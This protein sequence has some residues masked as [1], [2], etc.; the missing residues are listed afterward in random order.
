M[1]DDFV[2]LILT[3]R[4]TKRD[5][6]LFSNNVSIT[7][8][9]PNSFLRVHNLFLIQHTPPPSSITSGSYFFQVELYNVLPSV[10]SGNGNTSKLLL[11][12]AIHVDIAALVIQWTP[13]D[14]EWTK[15]RCLQISE[16]QN[17]EMAVWDDKPQEHPL[18]QYYYI[19]IECSITVP[20]ESIK[21]PS[22]LNSSPNK[23]RKYGGSSKANNST[24]PM[25]K[26]RRT[27]NNGSR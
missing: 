25:G 19:D 24:I 8:R 1:S 18:L 2:S 9:E 20:N 6:N 21:L 26:H 3:T 11:A 15:R 13:V 7:L 5:S 14:I 22:A 10:V 4:G 12:C 23:R 17:W 27:N 16:D